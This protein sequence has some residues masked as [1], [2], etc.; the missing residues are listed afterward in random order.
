M[1]KALVQSLFFLIYLLLSFT[2][3]EASAVV[4]KRAEERREAQQQRAAQQLQQQRAAQ[5]PQQQGA[6]RQPQQQQVPEWTQTSQQSQ[7]RKS[8]NFLDDNPYINTEFRP[9]DYET[10]GI[11]SIWEELEI[12]SEVWPL[13]MDDEP[14]RETVRRYIEWYL[15]QGVTIRQSPEHYVQ[16]IDSLAQ[17]NSDLLKSPFKDVLM[18]AAVME[19]DFD[20]GRDRDELAR[21]VL[22]ERLYTENRKRLGLKLRGSDE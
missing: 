3:T 19:Y 18:V 12:S 7:H 14:K 2:N 15:A 4:N 1:I 8:I 17:Q 21:Q 5:Q 10:V 20:N 6:A 22:G 16:E 13:I 11:N 9:D